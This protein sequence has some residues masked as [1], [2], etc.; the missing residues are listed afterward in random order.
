MS[1]FHA[2]IVQ[3]RGDW[4]RARLRD[5]PL[6]AS[7]RRVKDDSRDSSATSDR[8]AERRLPSTSVQS[9]RLTKRHSAMRFAQP[10][11][12]AAIPRLPLPLKRKT[13]SSYLRRGENQRGRAFEFSSALKALFLRVA[14]AVRSLAAGP[15][16]L[17]PGARVHQR[18]ENLHGVEPVLPWGCRKVIH[19]NEK[20]KKKKVFF[21]LIENGKKKRKLVFFNR[22]CAPL[23]RG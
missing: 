8:A 5:R 2:G 16:A 20:L 12:G 15:D 11:H 18:A 10:V 6:W 22:C 17:V 19:R 3:H 4:R 7:T 9:T 23:R 14:R 13:C 1:S 21:L